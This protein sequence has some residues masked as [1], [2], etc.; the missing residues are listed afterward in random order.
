LTGKTG[1]SCLS[2]GFSHGI[3]CHGGYP[4]WLGTVSVRYWDRLSGKSGS[5]I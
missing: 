1:N 5:S 2:Y 4:E 3:S